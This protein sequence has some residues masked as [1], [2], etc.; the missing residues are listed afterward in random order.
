[1]A[2]VSVLFPH[3][4]LIEMRTSWEYIGFCATIFQFPL[5]A[6]MIA[7]ASTWNWTLLAATVIL[8]L[9]SIAAVVAVTTYSWW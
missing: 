7:I 9:H 1:M 5:Y 3:G 6:T 4:T 2:P 8:V